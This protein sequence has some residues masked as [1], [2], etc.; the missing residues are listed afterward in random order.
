MVISRH[1]PTSPHFRLEQLADGV[2]AALAIEADGAAVGNAGIIDL[3][4]RT[5]I[6]DTF[7]TP[8]AAQ[9]L[10]DA[11]EQLTGRTGAVVVVSHYHA[12]HTRGIQVFA[13]DAPAV[14][15]TTM[16]RSLIAKREARQLELDRNS[17][18]L[19][20]TLETQIAAEQDETQRSLVSIRLA[21]LHNVLESLDDLEPIDQRLPSV[22]FDER[23]SLHGSRRSVVVMTYG[24]GHTDSDAFVVLPEERIGFLGDLL[25]VGT[26]AWMGHGHPEQWLRILDRIEALELDI[27]VPGHG[28]VSTP[29]QFD[30]V[31]RYFADVERLARAV[32]ET[33]GSA[34]AAA[35][36]AVPRAYRAWV[37]PEIFTANMQYWHAWLSQRQFAGR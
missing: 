2:F 30:V 33:G 21:T 32:V 37:A 18:S 23:L 20:A 4:D 11:A 26:H 13:A 1:I 10:R 22:T 28:T 17:A 12:D 9:E 31:R 19:L 36:S 35:A 27:L 34:Q 29:E 25:T 14:I 7:M 5:L 6:F 8:K 24:G 15:A 3:G 16:T